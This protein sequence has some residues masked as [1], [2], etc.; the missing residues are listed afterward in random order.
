MEDQIGRKNKDQKIQPWSPFGA[1]GAADL[2]VESL[3]FQVR[4]VRGF[5]PKPARGLLGQ[6]RGAIDNNYGRQ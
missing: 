1:R 5:L 3:Q 2:G 4:I 6:K